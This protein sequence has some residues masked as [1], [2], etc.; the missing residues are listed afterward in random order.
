MP[1]KWIP[2]VNQWDY[3]FYAHVPGHVPSRIV[4]DLSGGNYVKFD[5]YFD[6]PN[7]CDG[8]ASVQAIFLADDIEIY[9]SGVLRGNQARNTHISYDIPENTQSLTIKV[10]DG[11]DGGG[12]DHFIFANARLLHGD[13]S[14]IES[15]VSVQRSTNEKESVTSVE[16]ATPTTNSNLGVRENYWSLALDDCPDRNWQRRCPFHRC[17]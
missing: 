10:T 9:K 2:H 6:I 4:Y 13:G 8:I 3:W 17:R 5:A 14:V 15:A 11:G 7:P 12:C 1:A 16:D